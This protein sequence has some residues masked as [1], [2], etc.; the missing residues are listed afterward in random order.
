MVSLEGIELGVPEEMSAGSQISRAEFRRVVWAG[1]ENLMISL[2][3]IIEI[4]GLHLHKA[5]ENRR[6]PQK[7][8]GGTLILKGLKRK[9]KSEMKQP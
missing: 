3:M 2:E 4:K 9:N 7:P 5:V 1:D 6:E 8:L